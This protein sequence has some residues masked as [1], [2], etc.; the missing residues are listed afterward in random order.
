MQPVRLPLVSAPASALASNISEHYRHLLFLALEEGVRPTFY[1]TQGLRTA[2]IRLSATLHARLEVVAEQAQIDLK[3]AFASLCAAGAQI[4]QRRSA[5]AA[6]LVASFATGLDTSRFKSQQQADFY[7]GM[8]AGLAEKKIVFAEG[9]TGLG[10]GRVIAMCAREQALQ[11]KTPVVV[12]APSLALV[13]QLYAEFKALDDGSVPASAVVGAH[14]FVDD[15]ALLMYIERASVD[16][17]LP[18]DEGVRMWAASGAKPL[19]PQSVAALAAGDQAAWLMD[20]LR[21]LCVEMAPEDFALSEEADNAMRSQAREVVALM[22]ER[23]RVSEGVVFC[24][25][26]MLATAQRSQWQ[27]ALPAPKCLIVDEAHLLES[28]VSRVN[29]SQLSLFSMSLALQRYMLAQGL[30]SSSTAGKALREV[31][32][33]GQLLEPMGQLGAGEALT[34]ESPTQQERLPRVIDA[35]DGL[36]KRMDSRALAG[37]AHLDAYRAGARSILRGLR[38]E[39]ADKVQLTRSAVRGYPSLQSG[40]ASVALQLRHIWSTAEEGVALVSATLYAMGE[41]GE[42]HCDYARVSLSVPIGRAATVPPVREPHI[43]SIPTVHTL[44]AASFARFIPGQERDGDLQKGSWHS[45]L[46][47]AM[48]SIC[49]RARGGTLVLL[50]SYEDLNALAGLLAPDLG[51]RMVQ[52][53]R[54]RRFESLVREFRAKHAKGLRPVMLAL[55]VAWTGIDLVDTQ[56]EP[57]QDTMLTDLVV[58]RLPISLNHSATMRSRVEHQGLYPVINE[59]LLTLKQGLGRLIRRAGVKDRHIWLLDG[60]VHPSHAWPGMVR[61]TAGVRRML[62]DYAKRDEVDFIDGC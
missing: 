3:Q 35:L 12:C 16:P 50:T 30:S 31:K 20:D 4:Q 55:G 44:G 47:V 29:S 28:A 21:S 8:A 45:S 27:G 36:H 17:A 40:P 48:R 59:C 39:V 1:D 51:E 46:A 26:M 60:R 19:N 9:S 13:G 22:R 57:E 25:H 37:L 14:E 5:E 42:F 32:D 62:R 54:D 6:G 23:T 24:S 33:L 49:G 15:E 2:P 38:R 61:L 7:A 53:V 56:V 43:T 34:G 41:D 18:V 58:A 10:K 52:Q 11:G